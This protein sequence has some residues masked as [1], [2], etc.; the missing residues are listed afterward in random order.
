MAAPCALTWV[1]M[2]DPFGGS[3][4]PIAKP[5]VLY[6]SGDDATKRAVTATLAAAFEVVTVHDAAEALAHLRTCP[7]SVLC[8]DLPAQ[9]DA[10]ELLHRAKALYPDVG[11]VLVTGHK[12]YLAASTSDSLSYLVLLQPYESPE[13]V[14]LVERAVTRG[15]LHGTMTR[16]SSGE[17]RAV[18]IGRE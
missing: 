15:K 4:R 2:V 11:A 8:V 14:A 9:S 12:D 16:R 18:K 10:I 7:V 1:T 13:L 5:S 6:V 17:L 3:A